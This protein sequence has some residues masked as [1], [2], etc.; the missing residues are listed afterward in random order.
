MG[1]DGHVISQYDHKIT[2][3]EDETIQLW[4]H[5][6]QGFSAGTYQLVAKAFSGKAFHG[7]GRIY[8][9]V[10]GGVT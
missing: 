2:V 3:K 8:F 6:S 7:Q 4:V 10:K 1:N 5:H 9:R